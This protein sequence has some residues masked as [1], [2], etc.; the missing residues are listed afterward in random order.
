MTTI[1]VL[2]ADDHAMF[3]S[4]LRAVV[5]AHPD[6]ECVA[7]VGDAF[8]VGVGVDHGAQP[9]A[10]HGVVVGDQDADR[11]HAAPIGMDTV[12]RH[13]SAGSRPWST[14]PPNRSARR[15]MPSRPR[16]GDPPGSPHRGLDGIRRRADLFGGTV[17][18]GRD[19]AD[20]WRITVSIPIGAA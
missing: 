14:V 18:H 6:T 10:E 20:R 19:P 13:R 17:D 4:G 1:R 8:G 7:D 16:C 11:G 15:R 12:M 9:G 5:D 2:I 3:R